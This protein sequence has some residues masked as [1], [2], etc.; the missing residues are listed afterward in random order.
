MILALKRGFSHDVVYRLIDDTLWPLCTSG[1]W[2][3]LAIVCCPL[4]CVPSDLS[5]IPSRLAHTYTHTHTHTYLHNTHTKYTHAH[6]STRTH[7]HLPPTPIPRAQYR[8]QQGGVHCTGPSQCS[9]CRCCTD[10][11]SRPPTIRGF[12]QAGYPFLQLR[13]IYFFMQYISYT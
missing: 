6:I 1:R 8:P 5:S 3:T 13:F 7:T 12:V 9:L 2:Y 10:A 4:Q 11:A